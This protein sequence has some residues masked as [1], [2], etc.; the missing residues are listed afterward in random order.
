MPQ[1][2]YEENRVYIEENVKVQKR[3]N[4]WCDVG[5]V[6]WIKTALIDRLAKTA[7]IPS[8]CVKSRD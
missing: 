5:G 2:R 3:E 1:R 7:N 6:H 4:Y 8:V